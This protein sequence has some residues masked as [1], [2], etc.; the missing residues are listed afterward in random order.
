M[1]AIT[2][3]HSQHTELLYTPD[4][5]HRKRNTSTERQGLCR[6]HSLLNDSTV[7]LTASQLRN[8]KPSPS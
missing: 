2:A 7:D 5:L 8:V 1:Y 3:L 6:P 4:M